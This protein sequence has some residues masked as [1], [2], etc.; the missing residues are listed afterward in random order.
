MREKQILASRIPSVRALASTWL[1]FSLLALLFFPPSAAWSQEKFS[2]LN[3]NT[4]GPAYAPN[5]NGRARNFLRAIGELQCCHVILLQEVWRPAHQQILDSGLLANSA[6]TKVRFDDSRGDEKNIGLVS[7]AR[8]SS[9]SFSSVLFPVNN[10]SGLD[11]AR[12]DLGI[13]KGIGRLR[14]RPSANAPE[15]DLWQLHTHPQVSRVRLAQMV[16]LA[17]E[18]LVRESSAEVPLLLAGDF[19][20][21]P[22]SLEIAFVR[23]VLGFADAWV[24]KNGPYQASD[25]TYCRDNILH[26]GGGD[27][28][29]D[30]LFLRS[31]QKI[32]LL[33]ERAEF[34]LQRFAN[35]PLSDHYAV[36]AEISW[37]ERMSNRDSGCARSGWRE[38][39]ERALARL[40][41]FSA[42]FLASGD[43]QYLE[44]LQKV[45]D[46]QKLFINDDPAVCAWFWEEL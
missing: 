39:K 3:F 7:Y 4:Y 18:L 19:N 27:R 12:E 42:E 34:A 23:E 14:L 22:D 35:R 26:L 38:R 46:L 13:E 31:S 29:I 6:F 33:V 25:C 15:I 21:L 41:N 16:F 45:Y 8:A 43:P 1:I 9:V 17:S 2:V 40:D 20:A 5:T 28:V 30:Y 11:D 44:S 37:Q 36:L 10:Q 32:Q 24:Q